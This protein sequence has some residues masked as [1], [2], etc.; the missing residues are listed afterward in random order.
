MLPS[1][2]LHHLILR[3]AGFP[4]VATSGNLSDEPICTGEE[5][6]L[7]RLEG[8]ADL[9]LVHDRPIARHVDDSVAWI[10]RGEARLLRRARGF[11]PLPIRLR[12]PL[13]VI[14]AVGA[15]LK[16]TVALSVGERVF[17]SQHISDLETGESMEAFRRVIRD[18]LRLYDV[19]PAA[20]AHDL[21]PDYLS[22][23]WA[24][25]KWSDSGEGGEDP[26]LRGVPRIPVQHH[27]AHLAAC[28]A[29]NG[30]EGSV[31]GVTWDGTGYGTDGTVWGGEFL[32]GSAGG[33]Q[34]VAHLLPFRLPGGEAAVRE[35]RRTALALLWELEGAAALDRGDL[36][37]VS[38]FSE[39]ERRI[40]ARMLSGGI[41]SPVTSSAGRLF[42][43][44]SALLGLRQFS[45]F[46]GQAAMAL[47]HAADGTVKEAYPLDLTPARPGSPRIL[48]WRPAVRAIL[49]DRRR[50]TDP[51]VMAA[52]FQNAL[53]EAIVRVAEDEGEE[54]VALTGGCFQNRRLTEEAARGLEE[55]GFRVLLHRQVPPN[56][57]GISL[58]QVA[59]AGM[60]LRR[61]GGES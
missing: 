35:P 20:V 24:L 60:A 30:A 44:V 1:T 6:A 7:A 41:H 11:A 59:V 13:P 32:R 46:E 55:A 33:F 8:I 17:V 22:T 47:E 48:D 14:L 12:K 16:S 29:E 56:D 61:S 31:L 34:R 10:L 40:L 18:F 3:D 39:G 57:G 49:E 43:G 19:R 5:Q 52:R 26:A 42:D 25:E 28:M 21:H 45:G 15:H 50:G 23:R 2:P 38:S 54:R 36:P 58:G 51:R 37:S 9:F 53:V 4:L 27:H